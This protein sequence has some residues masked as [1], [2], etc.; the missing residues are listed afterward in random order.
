MAK[1]FSYLQ[2][3]IGIVYLCHQNV[4]LSFIFWMICCSNNSSFVC[5]SIIVVKTSCGMKNVFLFNF[6][7]TNCN[8]ISF[9]FYFPYFYRLKKWKRASF[10]PIYIFPDS[11]MR[12][13]IYSCC[14]CLVPKSCPTLLR[15]H[16]LT[17]VHGVFQA[18]IPKQVAFSF[19]SGLNTHL[20]L[21]RQI[22]Y[23]WATWEAPPLWLTRS[24][25]SLA[26]Q[27]LI[28]PVSRFQMQR[29]KN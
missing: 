27:A 28:V 11:L 18:R 25:S 29:T 5:Q 2:I 8:Q 26:V 12:F 10:V 19:S 3:S 4:T 13:S 6:P 7:N 14:C 23:H 1:S 20:L 21:C 9:E 15:P 24:R 17:S 22:L 16:G